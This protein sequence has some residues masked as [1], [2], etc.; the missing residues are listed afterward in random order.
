MFTGIVT[1]RGRLQACED[2]GGDL[3]M[4]F[5][6]DAGHMQGCVE[7]DSIA[8]NG[9]CLTMIA[10]TEAGFGADVSTETLDRTTL[11]RLESGGLVNL[12]L[13]LRA[14]DRMGGHLVSGHVDGKAVLCSRHADA[15]AERFEF[16]VPPELAKFVAEKG[17]ISLDGVSLTVNDVAGK[18]FGVCLIPH[19]LEVTSL[20]DLQPGDEVNV[21]VDMIARYL[22]R[23]LATEG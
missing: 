20:G 16:E 18:R 3:R 15:R 4:N 6:V 13:P 1:H 7:G 19:T 22:E 8:V 23:L 5:A 14:A 21:E 12:E 11:G 17:S 9:V 10:P 2:R